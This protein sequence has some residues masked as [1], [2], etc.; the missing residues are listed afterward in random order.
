MSVGLGRLRV[1]SIVECDVYL[2]EAQSLESFKN[3]LRKHL[4]QYKW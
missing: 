1:E 4:R 3:L 2:K